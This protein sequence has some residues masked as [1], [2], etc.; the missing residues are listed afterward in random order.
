MNRASVGALVLVLGLLASSL[1][2]ADSIKAPAA[3]PDI[4]AWIAKQSAAGTLAAVSVAF[5]DGASIDV[6]GAGAIDG[7]N[8][9]APD[10]DTQFQY[11]SI[12]KVFTHL[13][14]AESVKAGRA[15]YD[16]TLG[17]LL[18][19][20]FKPNNPAVATITLA[21]LATHHSGLPRLPAN[22]DLGN[23]VDPYANYDQ[24]KLMSGLTEARAAQPLGNFYTY[25]NFGVG[26]LGHVL[27]TVHG[28]GYRSAL[29]QS[30]VRPLGL[31][32]T[33]FA[34]DAHAATP[35]SG[36]E[37]VPTWHFDEAMAG[38]GA[39]WGSAND[40]AR[41]VQAYL[42]THEHQLQHALADD[43]RIVASADAFEVTYVWHVARAN[44]NPVYWHN[45]GTAGFHSFV[46]FRVDDA[47]GITILVSGDADPTDI[48]LAALGVVPIQPKSEQIDASV[49]GQYELTEQFGIGVYADNGRLAAQ[50]SGQAP[51]AL[52][53]LGDDWYALGDVD[54]SLRFVR[55]DGKV[56]ALELAQDQ[57]VQRAPRRADIASSQTKQAKPLAADQLRAYVGDFGFAPGVTLSV[58]RENDTL[59]AR[60]TGQPAFPVFARGDDRFFYK[61]VDA[62]LQFER[63]S[64]GKV[65]AVVLHQ[66]GVEQ[67]AARVE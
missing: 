10:G 25:S 48:G 65:I 66:G 29:T 5:V 39:L 14:L 44:G 50:A 15:R 40:L 20:S 23:T 30:V 63:D 34:P 37:V 35:V 58:R 9:P 51:M 33:G 43:L 24:S 27:G 38:A 13:L 45:G 32:R 1:A 55:K 7:E 16:A 22:L 12:S 42:G 28:K 59:T 3:K 11:G 36:G 64:S 21:S 18:P 62:E 41:L 2:L 31:T 17:S 19:A 26:L 49:F 4:D 6:I 52:H 54:A 46:G 8:G 57:Q 67:R 56:V 53:P 61:V 60:L 47:R